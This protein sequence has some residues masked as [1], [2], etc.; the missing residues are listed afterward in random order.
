MPIQLTEDIAKRVRAAR[1]AA[2]YKSAKE[3]ANKY[4][5]PLSTYSQHETGKRSINAELIINYSSYFTI[6]P[7]WLLTGNGEP[8]F[9]ED[10]NQKEKKAIIERETFSISHKVNDDNAK[11]NQVELGLM[12]KIFLAAEHLF[13]DKSLNVSYTGLVNHCFEIYETV[14]T[15]AA[16]KE[17][18]EK[19]IH[20]TLSAIKTRA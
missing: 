4:E 9:D 8:F 19:I 16:D 11:Y 3:F 5:I 2:G 1:K 7:C 18:K 13:A 14:S 6:N 12:R 20:L 10:Q 15:L 17:E